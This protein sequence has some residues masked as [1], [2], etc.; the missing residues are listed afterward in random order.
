MN[1]TTQHSINK[2]I[3]QIK[4]KYKPELI[5]LF[6]SYARGNFTEGSDVDLLVVKNTRKRPIWRRVDVRKVIDVDVPM[7]IIVYTPSEF[8]MLKE[9]NS[10][11]IRDILSHGKILYEKKSQKN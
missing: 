6:G 10:A 9:N 8:N 1:I 7:D 5:I 2:I 4:Q 3:D 11:F